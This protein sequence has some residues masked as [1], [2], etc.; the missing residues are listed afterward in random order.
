MYEQP[1]IIHER[2]QFLR[3]MRCNQR[4]R[5]PVVYSDEIRANA[6]DGWERTWVEHNK[7]I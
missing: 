2:H 3:R 5:R 1:H 4:E 7:K 6:R